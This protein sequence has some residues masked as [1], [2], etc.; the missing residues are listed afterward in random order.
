MLT[1]GNQYFEKFNLKKNKKTNALTIFERE[2][3]FVFQSQFSY[4][5]FKNRKLNIQ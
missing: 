1:K 2:S 4:V 5:N 3:H